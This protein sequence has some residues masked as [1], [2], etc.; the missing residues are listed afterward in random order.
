MIKMSHTPE[1]SVVLPGYNEADNI[2]SMLAQVAEVFDGMGKPYEIIYVDDGSN[3]ASE[4]ILVSLRDKFPALVP[5]F[6]KTNYGQSAAIHTGIQAARGTYVV[7]LDSDLQND[8][9][10]FP[11]MFEMLAR[12][13]RLPAP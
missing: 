2:A 3:D 7:T 9:G 11:A 5:L 8:P 4:A 13:R 10:D 1:I 12:K 6:H